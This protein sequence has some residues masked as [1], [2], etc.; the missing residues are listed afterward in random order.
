MGRVFIAGGTSGLGAALAQL[1]VDRG[2]EVAVCGGSFDDFR[3]RL[4][5]LAA[6]VIFFE[7]DVRQSSLI[8]SALS[9][10]AAQPI[11]R[12]IYSAGINNGRPIAEI[13]SFDFARSRQIFDVNLIGF[14]NFCEHALPILTRQTH[15]QLACVSSAAGWVGFRGSAAYCASKSALMIFCES[16]MQDLPPHVHLTSILPGYIDTPLARSTH[17]DIA[18]KPLTLTVADAARRSLEAIDAKKTYVV[19][20]RRLALL[21]YVIRVLPRPWLHKVLQLTRPFA[22]RFHEVHA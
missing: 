17:P 6:R 12:F 19:F 21:M 9:A 15:G 1:H 18:D 5:E 2:D 3:R 14:L 13:K 20:P 8:S 16:L 22:D 11:D 4:P 7:V 10:F